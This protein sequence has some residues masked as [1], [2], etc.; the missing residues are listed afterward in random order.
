M[1][2]TSDVYSQLWDL[3]FILLHSSPSPLQFICISQIS[4]LPYSFGFSA[5]TAN[6]SVQMI[7]FSFPILLS[8]N[9]FQGS[10][11][12]LK[13]VCCSGSITAQLHLLWTRLF[14]LTDREYLFIWTRK[15]EREGLWSPGSYS[16]SPCR[17]PQAAFQETA[18][19][20]LSLQAFILRLWWIPLLGF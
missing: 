18:R 17:A 6:V 15:E 19:M 1:T 3:T 12:N 10:S 2:N 8:L 20:C 11:Y 9:N 7:I 5:K 4:F 14:V 16:L 13:V